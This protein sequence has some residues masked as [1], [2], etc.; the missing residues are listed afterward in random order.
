MVEFNNKKT[1]EI[2]YGGLMFSRKTELS[3]TEREDLEAWGKAWCRRLVWSRCAGNAVLGLAAVL[4]AAFLTLEVL[5]RDK[6]LTLTAICLAGPVLLPP[7]V[8]TILEIFP[9]YRPRYRALFGTAAVLALAGVGMAAGL[10]GP[11]VE[12]PA[13]VGIIGCLFGG[14]GAIVM[15]WRDAGRMK[16]S[17]EAMLNDAV[18][19]YV[20]EFKIPDEFAKES[21][22]RLDVLATSGVIW[23]VNGVQQPELEQ[24]PVTAAERDTPE[25]DDVPWAATDMQINGS[26]LFQR[27]I[28]PSELGPLN[29]LKTRMLLRAIRT[30][31]WSFWLAWFLFRAGENLADRRIVPTLSPLGW[32]CAAAIALFFFFRKMM[33]RSKL[34]ADIEEMRLCRHMKEEGHYVVFLPR[35]G[36]IWSIDGVPAP[37]RNI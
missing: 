14:W 4:A 37:W 1:T 10:K 9:G 20:L 33:E 32:G 19:G 6:Y 26:Q 11:L 8:G 16:K 30:M 3:E 35:S 17:T 13:S 12:I 2:R 28:A 21:P 29:A 18:T 25:E 5:Y 31:A 22:F 34:S 24:H 23:R 7:I 15:R 36:L 27:H